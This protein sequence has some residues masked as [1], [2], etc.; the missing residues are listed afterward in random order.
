MSTILA[1]ET[2][3]PVCSV[4]ICTADSVIN[5]ERINGRGVHSDNTFLFIKKL[6]DEQSVSTEDLK[7][8]LFSHGP[9][10]YT[11]LRIG[12]SAIKGLL[13]KQNVPLYSLSSLTSFASPFLMKEPQTVHAVI[14]ARREHLYY[15]KIVKTLENE[16]QI[17]GETV[18][19]IKD[20]EASIKKGEIVTGT[21]LHRLTH[22]HKTTETWYN[23][24]Y[25]SAKNLILAWNNSTLHHLFKERDVETFEP[26]YL[27]MS[28]LNDQ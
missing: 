20:I 26:E 19:K 22:A 7:A 11:G 3:T 25:I 9:G 27:T 13:F 14:D 18:L 17:S 23:E 12:A 4:A 1:I 5:E 24:D 8:V 10:S 15:Q 16:L 28:Q 21:G 6:M 2:S